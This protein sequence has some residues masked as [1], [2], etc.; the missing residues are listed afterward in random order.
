[1][2]IQKEWIRFG[3]R[4]E[5]EN[6]ILSAVLHLEVNTNFFKE[7][8]INISDQGKKAFKEILVHRMEDL[9]FENIK[10]EIEKLRKMTML[11][12]FRNTS[13]VIEILNQIDKISEEL[14]FKGELDEKTHTIHT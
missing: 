1:M 4:I 11:A 5:G 10:A 7:R 14:E 8:M 2:S 12:T 13:Y 3:K 9:V 6:V